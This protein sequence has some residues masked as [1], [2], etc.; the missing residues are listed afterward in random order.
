MST[1][2]IRKPFAFI[3]F[4]SLLFAI[5]CVGCSLLEPS[6]EGASVSFVIAGLPAQKTVGETAARNEDT[7]SGMKIQI[8]LKGNTYNQEKT[9]EISASGA[10]KITFDS[11]PVG[12]TVTAKASV[13]DSGNQEIYTGTSEPVQIKDGENTLKL[14][15]TPVSSGDIP[16]I[17]GEI[18]ID[19]PGT[20]TLQANS[21]GI[22]IQLTI[23]EKTQSI[24]FYRAEY[25]EAQYKA[26]PNKMNWYLIGGHQKPSNGTVTGTVSFTDYYVEAGKTYTYY[27]KCKSNK[28]ENVS[29]ISEKDTVTARAGRGLLKLANDITLNIA[30]DTWEFSQDGFADATNLHCDLSKVSSSIDVYFRPA[31]ETATTTLIEGTTCS[32][33]A[34]TETPGIQF[35]SPAHIGVP[36]EIAGVK[37]RYTLKNGDEQQ[38]W[39][40]I[41][42]KAVGGRGFTDGKITFAQDELPVKIED[43]ETGGITITSYTARLA[44]KVDRI[45]ITQY[46]NFDRENITIRPIT[47]GQFPTATYAVTEPRVTAGETDKFTVNFKKYNVETQTQENFFFFN[48]F[49]T[50][51]TGRGAEKLT[52]KIKVSYDENSQTGYITTDPSSW[53]E[54]GFVPPDT[55]ALTVDGQTIDLPKKSFNP[56]V[57]FMKKDYSYNTNSSFSNYKTSDGKTIYTVNLFNRLNDALGQP[58]YAH[59]IKATADYRSDIYRVSY[60]PAEDR[61]NPDTGFPEVVTP[62]DIY[63]GKTYTVVNA[64][65]G[66]KITFTDIS[67]DKKTATV[68]I[69]VQKGTPLTLT[70]TAN[71]S[72]NTINCQYTTSDGYYTFTGRGFTM[73]TPTTISFADLRINDNLTPIAC[74]VGDVLLSNGTIIPYANISGMTAEQKSS[75]IG[76]LYAL[77]DKGVPRGWVGVHNSGSEKYA[78]TKSN[79]TLADIVCTPSQDMWMAASN[80]TFTGD[81][82]GS[83]NWAYIC[84]KDSTGTADAKT[85]YPAFNWVNNYATTYGLTGTYAEGWYMPSIAEICYLRRYLLVINDVLDALGQTKLCGNEDGFYYWSS[86]PV[87]GSGSAYYTD[88]HSDFISTFSQSS[89][90]RVCCIRKFTEGTVTPATQP[91]YNVTVRTIGA[92]Y[93]EYEAYVT[94]STGIAFRETVTFDFKVKD[95]HNLGSISVK[96][97][98]TDIPMVDNKFFTMPAGDVTVVITLNE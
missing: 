97:D 13:Y 63:T 68:T 93:A 81:T 27:A 87:S 38:S 94:K 19:N 71:L 77:D 8:T 83:D 33:V 18:V 69:T 45:D 9:E 4:L 44:E 3:S 75:A 86:S 78:W 82:D 29:A 49:Y 61:L 48:V 90:F 37:C 96:C 1:A 40:F 52:D 34:L 51:K 67:E 55:F 57:G 88:M 17:E 85:N 12:E 58:L 95:G 25:D 28:N 21:S 54:S 59:R 23:T 10:T 16:P 74:S 22:K 53:Y 89:T 56:S 31:N 36:L 15:L 70:G 32:N 98:N 62:K 72:N 91:T 30:K 80:A 76:I 7:A 42:T 66:E 39:H 11:I 60:D 2:S 6:S 20:M 92:D 79:K 47:D 24:N 35:L 43:A 14:T 50:P 46:R 5:F 73:P 65:N 26:D 41:P 84:S 64:K